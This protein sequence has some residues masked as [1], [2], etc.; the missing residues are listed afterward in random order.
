MV[1]DDITLE[2]LKLLII[3]TQI[4]PHSLK[5]M[6]ELLATLVKEG[7]VVLFQQWLPRVN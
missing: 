2:E 5:R 6:R 4:S 7:T 3:I 1:V